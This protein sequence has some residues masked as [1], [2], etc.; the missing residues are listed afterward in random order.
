VRQAHEP[1]GWTAPWHR[2]YGPGWNSWRNPQVL[3]GSVD[4]VPSR[5]GACCGDCMMGLYRS[6]IDLDHE[7]QV[8]VD[9]C[10]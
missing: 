10:V 4:C 5:R 8:P 7:K 1:E 3:A 2:R 6:F 9:S